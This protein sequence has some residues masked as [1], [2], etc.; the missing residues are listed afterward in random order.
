MEGGDY[1]HITYIKRTAISREV[2]KAGKKL[3]KN[4][5][6]AKNFIN[7]HIPGTTEARRIRNFATLLGL[8]KSGYR[9]S[10][11]GRGHQGERGYAWLTEPDEDKA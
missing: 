10:I 11:G 4:I 1:E 7:T 9:N 2:Q 5:T 6:E 8:G 3:F